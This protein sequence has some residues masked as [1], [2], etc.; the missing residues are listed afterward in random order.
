[1]RGSTRRISPGPGKR[2]SRAI[3]KTIR[4]QLAGVTIPAPK[5]ANVIAISSVCSITGPSRSRMINTTGDWLALT[6]EMS[7][8]A[9]VSAI[10]ST[11]PSSEAATTDPTIARGT[12]R[13]GSLAFSARFAAASKPT[14]VVRPMT[15]ASI[16]RRP[17]QSSWGRSR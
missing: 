17:R 10:K 2:A 13:W 9:T 15:M 11:S 3:A 6:W 16:N 5:N 12:L 7:S 8:M 14:S 4:E 1:V